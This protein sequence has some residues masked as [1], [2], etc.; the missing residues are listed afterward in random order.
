MIKRLLS[1]FLGTMLLVFFGCGAAYIYGGDPIVVVFAFGFAMATI[2]FIFGETSGCHVNPAVSLAKCINGKLGVL[3]CVEYILVQVLGGVVGA[4][5]LGLIF[6]SYENL[7]ANG[8]AELSYLPQFSTLEVA[9]AI[10]IILTAVFVLSVLVITSKENKNAPL[11]IGFSLAVVHIFGIPFTGTSVNPARSIGP[12]ILQGGEALNQLWVFIVAP[13]AGAIIAA[14]I[15]KFVIS[16]EKTTIKLM[17]NIPENKVEEKI[18]VEEEKEEKP[19]K[20][21]TTKK[22]TSKTTKKTTTKKNKT[23][24]A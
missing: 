5:I 20:K 19:A 4:E 11:G 24:K 9:I 8:Y 22:T 1:E 17:E 10:E 7:G 14:L 6:N 12:A 15:Y 2:A 21:T 3:E 13:L 16:T 18:E 23:K